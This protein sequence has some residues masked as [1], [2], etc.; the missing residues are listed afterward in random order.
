[1]AYCWCAPL[2]IPRWS[3]YA[4]QHTHTSGEKHTRFHSTRE[5]E[6]ERA[7]RS[8]LAS[9]LSP[10]VF[11]SLSGSPFLCLGQRGGGGDSSVSRT[12]RASNQQA[13]RRFAAWNAF[14]FRRPARAGRPLERDTAID[15]FLGGWLEGA[16]VLYPFV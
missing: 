6:R 14:S 9:K 1:M 13:I 5:R 3:T 10:R 7:L 2:L 12:L 16:V 15:R 4:T 11:L 8:T